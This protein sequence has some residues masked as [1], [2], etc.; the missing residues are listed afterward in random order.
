M[1][2]SW[3][4]S[5]LFQQVLF[6]HGTITYEC[7]LV[8]LTPSESGTVLLTDVLCW[9]FGSQYIQLKFNSCVMSSL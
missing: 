9:G 3:K 1:N 8:S 6:S 4:K 2:N 5:H 7:S